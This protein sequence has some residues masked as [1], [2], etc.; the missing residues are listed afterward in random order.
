MRDVCVYERFRSIHCGFYCIVVTRPFTRC[1]TNEICMRRELQVWKSEWTRIYLSSVAQ[2]GIDFRNS[3]QNI[4]VKAQKKRISYN[5][6]KTMML[7]KPNCPIFSLFSVQE[8]T[9]FFRVCV[10]VVSKIGQIILDAFMLF[11]MDC[12]ML[13]LCAF[14]VVR[15]IGWLTTQGRRW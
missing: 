7:A 9:W 5:N 8:W 12:L 6:I 2:I 15:L 13:S 11:Q 3:E 14:R 1:D 10:S 4:R